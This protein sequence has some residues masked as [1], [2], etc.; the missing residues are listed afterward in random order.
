[1][2]PARHHLAAT[3]G[4]FLALAATAAASVSEVRTY[5]HV[6]APGGRVRI[7]NV[8]GGIRV[9]ASDGPAVEIVATKT[10]DSADGLA[11]IQVDVEASSREVS[12]STDFR[13]TG[14]GWWGRGTGNRSV[15]Y[16]IRLPS[17]VTTLTLESVNG[18]I[19]VEG[20][21]AR[22]EA[23]AVNGGIHLRGLTAPASI[24]TVNGSVRAEFSRLVT[25]GS[26]SIESVNG[27][28]SIVVPPDASADFR[29]STVNGSI[30]NDF[31]LPVTRGL[32]GQRFAGR[33]GAGGPV[34]SLETVNGTIR[35]ETP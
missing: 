12:V 4:T 9:S 33:I 27:T 25:D 32:H 8:N 23:S 10:A 34:I 2:N 16:E 17:A 15:A 5:S 6:I 28:V 18:G 11:S 13:R 31:G 35:I 1:M 14:G 29:A 7:E 22:V 30:T 20:A 21:S 24:E 19:S 26:Y 3:L